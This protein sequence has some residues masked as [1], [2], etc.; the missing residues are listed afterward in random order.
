MSA[1][2]A[3]VE[4][5]CRNNC[6]R[7]APPTVNKAPGS[8]HTKERASGRDTEPTQGAISV[9]TQV[10]LCGDFTCTSTRAREETTV[11][12]IS[13]CFLY[14]C[15]RV[16]GMNSDMLV[17]RCSMLLQTPIAFKCFALTPWN[18]T[19]IL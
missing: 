5:K 11:S 13:D 1:A 3:T 10:R 16:S 7:P 14:R 4:L 17:L 18:L 8:E 6:K 2:V 12:S 15:N 9:S 19:Y